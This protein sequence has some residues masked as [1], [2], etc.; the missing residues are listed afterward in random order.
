LAPCNSDLAVCLE[1]MKIVHGG[2][3]QEPL[4]GSTRTNLNI[5]HHQSRH[6]EYSILGIWQGQY[7]NLNLP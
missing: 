5:Q 7:Q 4:Q 3:S 2:K 1:F 6:G